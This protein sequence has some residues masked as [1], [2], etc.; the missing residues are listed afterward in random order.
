MGQK[1][2]SQ[3]NA[4]EY[5][6]LV[7]KLCRAIASRQLNRLVCSIPRKSTEGRQNCEYT[8]KT[9]GHCLCHC[10]KGSDSEDQRCTGTRQSMQSDTNCALELQQGQP[11]TMWAQLIKL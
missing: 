1:K 3:L 11:G 2:I 8:G 4:V 7:W 10:P 5:L 6:S 9:K